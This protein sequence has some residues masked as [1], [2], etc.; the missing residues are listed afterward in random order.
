M[1]RFLTV[2]FTICLTLGSALA[3]AP[4]A[5]VEILEKTPVFEAETVAGTTEAVD[6]RF[7]RGSTKI[8]FEGSQLMPRLSGEATV[9]SG[10]GVTEISAKFS[11]LEPAGQF[12]AEYLTYVLWAISPEGRA[13]NI[14]E[15]YPDSGSNFKLD[16]TTDLQSF[17]MIVTAEPYFSVRRPSNV[18][19]AENQVLPETRGGKEPVRTKFELLERGQYEK[20]GNPLGMQ[21]DT[22][23]IP[24]DLYQA[25]NAVQVARSLSAEQ[26]A[27]DTF[28]KAVEA[29]NEAEQRLL[30]REKKK[31]IADRARRAVQIAEDSRELAVKRAADLRLEAERREAAEREMRARQSAEQA[32]REAEEAR[33]RSQQEAELRARAEQA[34]TAAEKEKLEA[35]LAAS[36]AREDM[37]AALRE[38]EAAQRMIEQAKVE[39]EQSRRERQ[40]LEEAT[41]ESRRA[42]EEARAEKAELRREAERLA[43]LRM[44]AEERAAKAVAER[45]AMEQR[46]QSA[47]GKIVETRDSARG[48]ILNLPDILFDFGKSTLRAEARE[49][50]SR[51]AGVMMVTPGYNLWI[52][53]HTDSIGSDEANL[54]LSEARA[55]A[56]K[57]YFARNDIDPDTITT[58]GLGKTQPVA[59]N[60]TDAGRQKNRRVEI[61]IQEEVE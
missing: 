22:R 12:G 23:R 51:I 6:Y 9:K 20:L 25:R 39:I 16:V 28:A 40:R 31:D 33:Q 3:Q 61:I 29:L 60:D 14:G 4:S 53:G 38:K 18:I 37:Q 54:K 1:S 35:E 45:D 10:R 41:M 7:R 47:L 2:P 21:V 46:M 15:V 42:V 34:V 5:G 56:V 26:L 11:G 49:T 58:V 32:A 48:L 13:Q 36:K 17:A 30:D 50:L 43:A 44:S 19:V 8:A 24:L 57:D 52:E 27:P 55:N 59:S